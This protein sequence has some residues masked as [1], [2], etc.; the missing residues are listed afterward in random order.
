LH[1]QGKELLVTRFVNKLSAN[2]AYIDQ[3]MMD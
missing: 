3:E 1:Q 2:L